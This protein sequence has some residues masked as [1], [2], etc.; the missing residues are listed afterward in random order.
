MTNPAQP[1]EHYTLEQVEQMAKAGGASE[2]YYVE[3]NGVKKKLFTTTA[4]ELQ[5][6]INA[7]INER[8]GEPVATKRPSDPY[9]ERGGLWFDIEDV[10]RMKALPVGTKL[11]TLKKLP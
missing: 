9:D 10:E 5:V 8:I 11:Y 4:G 2:W 6:L 7:A 3:S 1:I